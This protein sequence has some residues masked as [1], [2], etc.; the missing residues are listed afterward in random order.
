MGV[1]ATP[2]GE[3][4]VPAGLV[5]FGAEAAVVDLTPPEPVRLLEPP[6][7]ELKLHRQLFVNLG[8]SVREESAMGSFGR[9]RER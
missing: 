7:S 1:Q 5:G 8:L 2:V 3:Q 6:A 4:G 9:E